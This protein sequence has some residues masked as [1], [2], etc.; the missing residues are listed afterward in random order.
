MGTSF[1]EA[2]KHL[3]GA[4]GQGEDRRETHPGSV[5]WDEQIC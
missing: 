4:L 2:Q 5:G 1:R 3:P